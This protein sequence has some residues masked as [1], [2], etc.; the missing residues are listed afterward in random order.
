MEF[1]PAHQANLRPQF[2]SVYLIA[3]SN[4]FTSIER[5]FNMYSYRNKDS[6]MVADF[7]QIYKS[8]FPKL[9]SLSL[10]I[11]LAI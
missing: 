11:Y 2:Y 6:N 10:R 4:S 7:R 8:F 9:E 3:F 5:V 1:T